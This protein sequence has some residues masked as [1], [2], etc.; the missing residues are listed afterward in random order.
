MAFFKCPVSLVNSSFVRT[1][2]TMTVALESSIF[3]A[4]STD[5]DLFVPPKEEQE[6]AGSR[7]MMKSTDEMP[8]KTVLRRSF[9]E[10]KAVCG[11]CEDFITGCCGEGN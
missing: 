10:R 9:G 7:D 5:T 1:S 6:K 8:I 3:F 11:C 2:K 4:C